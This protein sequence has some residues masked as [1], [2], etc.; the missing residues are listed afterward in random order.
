LTIVREVAAQS[1]APL[2]D[3]ALGFE[4]A[5]RGIARLAE[6][7]EGSPSELFSED[8]IQLTDTGAQLAAVLLQSCFED[9]ALLD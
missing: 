6:A 9:A 5:K 2:C 1:G 4:R 3:L 7:A 8:G